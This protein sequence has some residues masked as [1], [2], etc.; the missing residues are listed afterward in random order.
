M[1]EPKDNRIGLIAGFGRF[2]IL[3]AQNARAENVQVIAV[4]IR[5]EA[6]PELEQHVEKLYW[7]G[8]AQLG[9]LIDILKR[10]GIRRAVMA[11]K[12]HKTC[13]YTPLRLLRLWPDLRTVL[14]WYRRLRD[15]RDDTLLS[16]VAEELA[17][18]GITLES[19]LRYSQN[20][21]ARE[22]VLT[23]SRPSDAE[24]RDIRFGWNLA[25]EMGGLDVGQ[26]VAVREQAVLA[27]EAI[28][29]T[30]EAIRRAGQLS[31]GGFVVVKV[32]KPDQDERFDVPTVGPDTVRALAESGG[33][34]LAVEADK[35]LFLDAEEALS[36]ADRRKVAV[37]ALREAPPGV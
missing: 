12:I 27:V 37:V 30:D 5:H 23:R 31:N 24:L 26:S 17:R 36:E 32:S 4:G 16:A 11:G 10:E 3:L 1:S 29:G 7:C 35:T 2:P 19:S 9:R 25:R 13:M 20:L 22:G 28:E 15:R 6:S 18:E 33:R 34:V 14:L 8:V 21:L